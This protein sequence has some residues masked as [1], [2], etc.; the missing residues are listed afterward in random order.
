VGLLY[1]ERGLLECVYQGHKKKVVSQI[2]S[3]LT[4][5]DVWEESEKA[6]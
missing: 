2:H 5:F 3:A 1:E 4:A 6:G